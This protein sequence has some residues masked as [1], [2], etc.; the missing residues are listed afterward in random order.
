MYDPPHDCKQNLRREW[1]GLLKSSWPFYGAGL[2]TIMES[3]RRWSI[4]WTELEKVLIP[5][6]A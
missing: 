4:E 6:Q 2:L 3:A 1:S 5:T